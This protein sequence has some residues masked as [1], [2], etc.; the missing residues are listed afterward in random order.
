[1]IRLS[2][3]FGGSG[4]PRAGGTDVWDFAQDKGVLVKQAQHWTYL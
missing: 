4:N 3:A 1:M 2:D